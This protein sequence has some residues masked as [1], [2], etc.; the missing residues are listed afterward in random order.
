M[1]KILVV[2]LRDD[3]A[4]IL[5]PL[6]E[7]Y[8]F[9][10][11]SQGELIQSTSRA[12]EFPGLPWEPSEGWWSHVAG[13]LDGLEYIDDDD[14]AG[15]LVWNSVQPTSRSLC[16]AMQTRGKPA[17][18]ID[19]GCFA[20]YLHGHFE[21]DPA[22]NHIFCSEEMAAFLLS[23]GYPLVLRTTTW[24][25]SM[26]RW[27]DQELVVRKAEEAFLHAFMQLQNVLPVSLAYS[28]RPNLG[29]DPEQVSR[30]MKNI[31]I[32]DGFVTKDANLKDLIQA[33]DVV[34]S[35]KSSAAVEA[36]L[37]DRPAIVVDFRPQLDVW[38]WENR[39]ILP[40][41]TSAELP[42]LILKCLADEETQDK[43]AKERPEAKLWF[44]GPGQA[45]ERIAQE[46]NRIC[47][48]SQVEQE[49]S[50]EPT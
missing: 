12:P 48:S 24:T 43:L 23:Y 32:E 14:L 38:A 4:S 20:T 26:S 22:A 9:S 28:I 36:V 29:M 11:L 17:F 25:H 18:E 2:N 39:G 40:C 13:A 30:D 5:S 8:G 44:N 16:L 10:L 15:C 21:S 42:H 34:V 19:H 31:G 35:P 45:A 33:A 27:S 37:L 50:A 49:V 6:A 1:K 46:I 3:S 47:S 7:K 41:R